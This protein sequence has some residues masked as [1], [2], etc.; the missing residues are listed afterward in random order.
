MVLNANVNY[1]AYLGDN[2]TTLDETAKVTP[3]DYKGCLSVGEA[4][5]RA[6]EESAANWDSFNRALALNELKYLKENG[7]EIVYEAAD[8]ESLFN[9]AADFVK[10]WLSKVFGILEKTMQ[11]VSASLA[12]FTKWLGVNKDKLKN[13]TGLTFPEAKKFKDKNYKAAAK[14]LASDSMQFICEGTYNPFSDITGNSKTSDLNSGTAGLADT[15]S[16]AT[17]GWVNG[18]SVTTEA[19]KEKAGLTD[20]EISGDYMGVAEVYG[21]IN[22]FSTGIQRINDDRKGAKQ[23]ANNMIKSINSLKKG[24]KGAADRT[25]EQKNDDSKAIYAAL[26]MVNKINGLNTT[27]LSARLSVYIGLLHQSQK[28]A[29]IYLSSVKPEKKGKEDGKSTE[30]Q[31]QNSS[32]IETALSGFQLI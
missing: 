3:A 25:K 14:A 10:S 22:G 9:K 20:I 23:A 29:R 1:E 6:M 21:H 2:T 13:G 18:D 27:L 11:Q 12:S 8:N 4:C 31:V 5:F 17:K 28:I 30:V 26:G 15:V 7:E 32:A 19:I 16:K 24:L